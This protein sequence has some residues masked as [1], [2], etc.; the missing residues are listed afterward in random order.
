MAPVGSD[1]R[2]SEA[3]ISQLIHGHSATKPLQSVRNLK[4]TRLTSMRPRVD[5]NSVARF[6]NAF[7]LRYFGCT[8]H[9][10][11][12]DVGMP[13]FSLKM[14]RSLIQHPGSVIKTS[15]ISERNPRNQ[16]NTILTA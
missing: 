6:C 11:A 7:R 13:S 3:N 8:E 15:I 9:Q 14:T 2:P 1:S 10:L 5:D 16:S 12:Q 4:I